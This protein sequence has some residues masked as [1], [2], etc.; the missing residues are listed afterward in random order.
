MSVTSLTRTELSF[1]PAH[2]TARCRWNSETRR[3]SSETLVAA[4]H[5]K[6][7]F[8][9]FDLYFRLHGLLTR[10]QNRRTTI[11]SV[12]NDTGK[13]NEIAN[14]LVNNEQFLKGE[15]HES[16]RSFNVY[17]VLQISDRRLHKIIAP[18]SLNSFHICNK[19]ILYFIMFM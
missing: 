15:T 18:T 19:R 13:I 3:S 5:L 7:H 14:F 2:C 11:R 12:Q 1:L 16:V 17:R 10:Y 6:C 8:A 4:T 9:S